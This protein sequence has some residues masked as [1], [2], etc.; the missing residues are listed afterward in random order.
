MSIHLLDSRLIGNTDMVRLDA[1]EF[2]VLLVRLVH[3]L[4]PLAL[5]NLPQKP[6]IREP[7]GEGS[8]DVPNG[9][10]GREVRHEPEE[11]ESHGNGI[12]SEEDVGDRHPSDTHT[13]TEDRLQGT[14]TKKKK[15]AVEAGY[16]QG[17][18]GLNFVEN[19]DVNASNCAA[20]NVQESFVLSR[21]R[22]DVKLYFEISQI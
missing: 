15:R 3:T 17:I 12:G 7:G 6:E 8:W 11:N 18:E 21:A 5:S 22:E 9:G 2:S 13:H 20:N 19:K 1:N 16:G 14:F 10:I 4:V